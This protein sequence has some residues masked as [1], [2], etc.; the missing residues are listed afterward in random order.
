MNK[1]KECGQEIKTGD[2]CN[3]CAV[4]LGLKAM[5]AMLERKPHPGVTVRDSKS[6]ATEPEKKN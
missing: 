5:V 3:G 1:C 6:N 2:V 4:A